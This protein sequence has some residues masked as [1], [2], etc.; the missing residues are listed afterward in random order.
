MAQFNM[1]APQH[2][3]DEVGRAARRKGISRC[4]LVR[5]AILLH[6]QLS[7]LCADGAKF[8][9]ERNG[10]RIDVVLVGLAPEAPARQALRKPAGCQ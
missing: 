10:K 1:S 8:H 7:E 6:Q 5:E 2:V 9:V 3:I 4:A